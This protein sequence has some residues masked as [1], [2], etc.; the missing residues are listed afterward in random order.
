MSL[1]NDGVNV[2]LADIASRLKN[3]FKRTCRRS[4]NSGKNSKRRVAKSE[5]L[6]SLRNKYLE[7][8]TVFPNNTKQDQT[9]ADVRLSQF[10]RGE[11]S[12]VIDGEEHKYDPSAMRQYTLEEVGAVM[13][14]TRE[15]VR[16]VEETAIRKMWRALDSISRREGI[17]KSEW[18]SMLTNGTS[19]DNTIY[20]P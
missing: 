14:V 9:N 19:T 18:M 20:M 1:Q 12:T 3:S 5:D 16:Q 2:L 10:M 7:P 8:P 11:R 17:T 13:G 6:R 15:R 4:K